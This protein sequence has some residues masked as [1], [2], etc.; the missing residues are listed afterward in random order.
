VSSTPLASSLSGRSS[1]PARRSWRRRDALPQS[2]LDLILRNKIAIKG[3]IHDAC[4]VGFRSVNVACARLSAC[5]PTFGRYGRFQSQDAVRDVDLVIVRE[6][7]EDL[8]AGIEHMVVRTPRRASSH[9]PGRFGADRPICFEYDRRQR[10]SQ[11]HGRPQGNIMKFS[12]GLFLDSCRT[13]AGAIRR[14]DRL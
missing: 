4:W 9:H 13:I 3:P 1:R 14:Q 12:D 8:Y 11:G 5:T 7:T 10:S 2:V 6:N